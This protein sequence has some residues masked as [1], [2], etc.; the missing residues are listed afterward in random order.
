MTREAPD[1]MHGEPAAG[2]PAGTE[3]P[4]R[5]GRW[6]LMLA[7]ALVLLGLDLARPASDQ[8]SAAVLLRMIHGYQVSVSPRLSAALG[9]SCRFRPT[10]SLY[11][12]QA[13]ARDG[14]L[15]GSARTAA[16]IARCGPWTPKGTEDPL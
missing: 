10:C 3:G 12:R 14:A 16:R 9:G 2:P 11:G 4:R 15:V 7:A 8:V 6:R 13:I 5:R 1:T